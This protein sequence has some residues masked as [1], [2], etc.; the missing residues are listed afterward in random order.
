RSV[1]RKAKEIMIA[2]KVDQSKPKDWVLEQY[3]NTI[4]FGRG[5]NGVQAAARAYFGKDVGDLTVAEGA[6]LAAV[7]RQPARSAAT[8][9]AVL[10]PAG[11]GRQSLIRALT[12]PGAL[13]TEQAAAQR[14]PELKA[15]KKPFRLKG[16]ARYMLQQVTDELNRRGY[17]DEDINGGG[18]K[19]VTTFDKKLMEAAERAVKG[20]LPES[21]PKKVRTGL[22]AVDPTTGEVLAFYGGNP[23][24]SQ[25][26]N[27]FSAKVMAG[28]T[29]KP[30]TLAAA[31]ESGLGLSTRVTGNSPMRGA[32]YP[33]LTTPLDVIRPNTW[34]EYA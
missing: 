14:F 7:I 2:I 26:D 11:A 16:Q 3:L 25:Y 30:Y 34:T 5:A 12:E 19:V 18:L 6:Y 31:L 29:F 10:K 4:Y 21:T 28:S 13:T 15:P 32:G 27:A 22:A 17:T 20:T 24:R 8:A 1:V 33:D 23:S 9:G